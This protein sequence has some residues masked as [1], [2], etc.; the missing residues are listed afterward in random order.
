MYRAPLLLSTTNV[1]PSP[2]CR[3]S[4]LQLPYLFHGHRRQPIARGPRV[5]CREATLFPP[6]STPLA[7]LR[8][9]LWHAHPRAHPVTA[10]YYYYLPV[11]P[12]RAR[13]DTSRSRLR[14]GPIASREEL[15][16]ILE[17]LFISFSVLSLS[18]R[19]SL[20]HMGISFLSLY[21]KNY[22]IPIHICK[23]KYSFFFKFPL[24]EPLK[25]QTDQL[26][27][28]WISLF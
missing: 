18:V 19:I 13:G 16:S 28:L 1:P 25:N 8:S 12:P 23:W 2:L 11:H 6:L 3:A 10:Y 21:L 20:N 7:F 14:K 5:A 4:L 24:H 9:A 26:Y 15:K 27:F 22:N 17:R